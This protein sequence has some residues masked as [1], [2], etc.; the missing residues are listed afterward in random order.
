MLHVDILYSQT[1]NSLGVDRSGVQPLRHVDSSLDLHLISNTPHAILG[2]LSLR[3][4]RVAGFLP[5]SLFTFFR[6]GHL[7]KYEP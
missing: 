6:P 5:S 3:A 1:S 4:A 7:F 2:S